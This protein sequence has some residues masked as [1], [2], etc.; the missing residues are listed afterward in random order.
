VLP[1][2]NGSTSRSRFKLPLSERIFPI[3]LRRAVYTP[4]PPPPQVPPPDGRT[5]VAILT[6]CL[7]RGGAERWMLDLLAACDSTRLQWIGLAVRD[8]GHRHAEQVRAVEATCPVWAGE[9]GCRELAAQAEVIVV[10]GIPE[11][12]RL[13]PE[14][15]WPRTVVVCQGTGDWSARTMAGC[16]R[17]RPVAVSRDGLRAVPADQRARTAVL[18]NGVSAERLRPQRSREET[19][20]AWGVPESAPALGFLGRLS[21]E[22][23]PSA[24]PVALAHL[25]GWYGVLG[26]VGAEEMLVRA[27][28]AAVG[29]ADRL[30]LPGYTEDVGG[31]LRAVDVLLVPSYEEGYCYSLVEAWLC[32][33]PTV[34]TPVGMAAERPDLVCG[35]ALQSGS[36]ELAAAGLEALTAGPDCPRVQAA[37]A[38][39]RKTQSLERFGAA[40]TVLLKETAA[41]AG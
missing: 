7:M 5:R 16:E 28:A 15:L 8:A 23:R 9:E 30:R 27:T 34:S 4:P 21:A 29:V 40:W 13:A 22:K 26:G 18:H 6:P 19:R 12:W 17:G 32:G 14:P 38:F 11:W 24:V 2:P 41:P 33:T 37:Q 10:W 25:P 39:A 3:M 1:I 35:I 31:F 36:E 20:R